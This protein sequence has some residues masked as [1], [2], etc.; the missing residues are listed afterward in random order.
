MGTKSHLQ[1]GSK[2]SSG[3]GMRDFVCKIIIC[4]RTAFVFKSWLVGK[5]KEVYLGDVLPHPI[6][7]GEY[8]RVS[9]GQSLID[10]CEST[11]VWQGLDLAFDVDGIKLSLGEI[12]ELQ[13]YGCLS[14]VLNKSHVG[15]T[16]GNVEFVH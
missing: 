1:K 6:L 10:V 13:L 8:L 7:L 4:Q 3:S 2:I 9:K 14:T 12:V 15:A 11:S 5:W 16:L